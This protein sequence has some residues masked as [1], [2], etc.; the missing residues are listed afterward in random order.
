MDQCVS[1]RLAAAIFEPIADV[2]Y[3][4]DLARGATDETVLELARREARILVTED[5]DFGRLI[6]RDG[7][8]PPPGLIHLVL[9]RMTKAERQAK[10]GAEAAALINAAPGRFVVFSKGPIRSRS[11]PVVP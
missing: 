3:I 11:L 7:E 1:R 2:A 10:L 9:A 6:F 4:W 5:F 8:L